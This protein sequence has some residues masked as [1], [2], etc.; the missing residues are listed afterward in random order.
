MSIRYVSNSLRPRTLPGRLGQRIV[1]TLK[2]WADDPPLDGVLVTY[3]V[4]GEDA[5]SYRV[6]AGEERTV[7]VTGTKG[8]PQ[9]LE[10]WIV[11]D[12]PEPPPAKIDLEAVIA[13]EGVTR[14]G[15]TVLLLEAK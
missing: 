12:G 2:L 6:V 4:I 3:G 11:V 5:E 9:E 13:H 8:S 14:R 10:H 15:A 1:L 7:V